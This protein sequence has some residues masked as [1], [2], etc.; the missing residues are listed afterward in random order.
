MIPVALTVNGRTL[1]EA[2]EPRTHLAD[3]L[4]DKLFLTG[5]HLRCEQGVC[6]ACTL[7]VDG[8]P[9]RSCITFAVLCDGAEVTTIEGLEDDP[10]V[11]ALRRAFTAEHALQCGYCTP[12]MLMT[13]RDI[14]MRLPDAD[15]G[16]I[17][18]E[19]SGNLC[20]CTGYVGIVAA[21]RRVIVERGAGT[22]AD[23]PRRTLGPVGSGHAVGGGATPGSISSAPARPL[24]SPP[25][26]TDLGLGANAPNLEVRDRFVVARPPDDVWNLLK[27]VARVVPCMP[28][29]SIT[30]LA[31]DRVDGRLMIK[32]GPINAEFSGAA[33]LRYDDALRR[34]TF[35]GSGQ[36]RLTGSRASG[37]IEFVVTPGDDA[38]STWVDIAV[39]AKLSGPLAQFARAGIV[40]DLARRLARTFAQNLEQELE[41][42]AGVRKGS[43]SLNIGSLLVSFAWARL[44]AWIARL[45][46]RRI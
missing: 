38:R 27:D 21:V 42:R 33:M 9:V 5:T 25:Q 20:R 12:A 46:R 39:L 11:A 18:R 14:V 45:F 26:P 4:R 29:A 22:T 10:I 44:C 32:L 31:G 37:A 36:D 8:Q 40:E 41:G 6:G 28:G 30:S 34:G 7:L 17:R 23:L 43:A 19:L 16:R 1:V 13:A 3:V 2:V 24:P 15:E 35:A